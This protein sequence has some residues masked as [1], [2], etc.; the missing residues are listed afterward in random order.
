MKSYITIFILF[1][2]LSS[3]IAQDYSYSLEGIT[4]VSITT[5]VSIVVK[6][7]TKNEL[8]IPESENKRAKNAEKS[9]GLRSVFSEGRKDN[10]A[11]GVHLEKAGNHLILKGVRSRLE[12]DLIVYLPSD[13]KIVLEVPD[14]NDIHVYN[15]TGDIEAKANNGDIVMKNVSGPMVVY[16]HNGH[17]TIVFDVVSQESP[18]SIIDSKGN[19]DIS[20]PGNTAADLNIKTSRGELYTD[21]NLEDMERLPD[22]EN[23]K[24]KSRAIKGKINTGGVLITLVASYG[25]VYIRKK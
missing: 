19:I 12:D 18:I 11:F 15:M 2:V 10:T 20:L 7:H 14:N 24:K 22:E 1:T 8:L 6:Q 3:C 21:F 9:E 4:K 13:M 25:D 5:E 16:N 17:V 23:P